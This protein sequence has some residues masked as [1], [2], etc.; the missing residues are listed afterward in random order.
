MGCVMERKNVRM[1]M[2]KELDVVRGYVKEE[3][4]EEINEMMKKW[5]VYDIVKHI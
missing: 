5:E 2:K 4:N 1:V 3:V